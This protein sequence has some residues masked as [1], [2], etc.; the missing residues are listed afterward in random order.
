MPELQNK[1]K[2]NELLKTSRD[3]KKLKMPTGDD[4][5]KS[6]LKNGCVYLDKT[7][8][9]KEILDSGEKAILITRP[10]RWGKTLAMSMLKYFLSLEVDEEGKEIENNPNRAFFDNFEIAKT[11]AMEKQGKYPVIFITLKSVKG[12]NYREVEDHFRRKMS[13]VFAEF[14]YIYKQIEKRNDIKDIANLAQFE[15]ILNC[16]A[17]KVDIAGSLELLSKLIFQYHGKNPFILIDEYDV[18]LNNTYNTDYYKD[19]L[20]L[21]KDFFEAGVKGNL[22]MEKAVITGVFKIAKAGL[23]TGM[24]NSS[25]YS[26]LSERYAQYF[27]FTENEVDLLLQLANVS[28]EA[29][30]SEVKEWYNGYNIGGLTIY[31]PW[32]IINFFSRLEIGPYWIG[33]EGAVEGDRKLSV[34]VMITDQIHDNVNLLIANFGKENTEITISKEVVFSTLSDDIYALWGLLLFGGYLSIES[35]KPAEF[36][37]CIIGQVRIPNREVLGVYKSSILVWVEEKLSIKRVDFSALSKIFN[38]EDLDCVRK[39]INQALKIYGNHIVNEN[40]SVFHG[41]IQ[42]LCLFNG[43][44]HRLAA[45]SYSGAGRVDSIFYPI[46]G[47]SNTII[48][49]EYKIIKD[50]KKE[51][52]LKKVFKDAIWQ[53]YK[54]IYIDVPLVKNKYFGGAVNTVELRAIVI[55]CDFSDANKFHCEIMTRKHTL[56]E[57]K[58]IT[59]AFQSRP[60]DK[61]R[62]EALELEVDA[63]VEKYVDVYM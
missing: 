7:L 47:K 9:A 53:I 16:T 38:L 29:M 34:N 51:S 57:M 27:G 39:T 25:D 31:N 3:V 19:T 28:D 44:K 43:D 49:H 36:G 11:D 5:F 42:S 2:A 59:K 63:E 18:P 30:R 8:F 4:D 50:L 13:A 48:I 32:S 6:V 15:R 37:N 35:F 54:K 58:R 23:W 14:A 26:I 33:T 46:E 20:S 41:L 24:N 60:Q 56:D 40:E 52:Q 61:D 62:I 10:R 17:D 22:H 12:V 45:E 1:D 55:L 21:I